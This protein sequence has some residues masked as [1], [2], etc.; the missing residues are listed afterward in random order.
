MKFEAGYSVKI[1]I[2]GSEDLIINWGDGASENKPSKVDTV[3]VDGEQVK[4]YQY[5]HTYLKN[6]VHTV[7]ITGD[8]ITHFNCGDNNLTYLDVSKNTSLIG[9]YCFNNQLTNIDVSKNTALKVLDCFNNQ[10]KKLDVSQNTTLTHLQCANNKLIDMD[11]SKNTALKVL[12]CSSNKLTDINV[13]RNIMLTILCCDDN[14][15]TD[16][17]VSNNTAL[18]TLYCSFNKF[19]AAALNA[20]F[21]SLHGNNIDDKKVTIYNNSGADA[22]NTKIAKDKGWRVVK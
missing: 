21:V 9:L 18:K 8:S 3:D 11:V 10:L 4:I 14:Q 2:I 6:T 15:L 5:S 16:L 17:D 22:C 19:S 20:L 13:S 7:T 1:D 12:D